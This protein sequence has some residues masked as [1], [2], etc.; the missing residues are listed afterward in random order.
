[1]MK[2][3]QIVSNID[4][5][6]NN[7]WYSEISQQCTLMIYFRNFALLIGKSV[8]LIKEGK[9]ILISTCVNIYEK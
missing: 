9:K 3:E 4:Y 5:V 6:W 7:F 8:F 2:Q 1:M